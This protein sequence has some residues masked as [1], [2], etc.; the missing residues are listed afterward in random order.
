MTTTTEKTPG[1]AD[2]EKLIRE[3]L[4]RE[5]TGEKWESDGAG[6]YSVEDSD[7]EVAVC[8]T[9]DAD[10]AAHI[11]A[12]NPSAIRALLAE[13]DAVRVKA[14]R[15]DWLRNSSQ[16][17]GSMTGRG[18]A[19]PSYET[20]DAQRIYLDECIDAAINGAAHD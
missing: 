5:L 7:F 2:H 4:G 15:Y 9:Q 17:C 13:L 11:A 1:M 10:D 19:M 20:S 16:I 14:A 18:I 12:C 8:F 6:V 3:A